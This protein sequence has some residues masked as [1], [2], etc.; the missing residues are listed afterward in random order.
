MPWRH[1]GRGMLDDT[2][3]GRS[4]AEEGGSWHA[5]GR[6]SSQLP[7]PPVDGLSAAAMPLQVDHTIAGSVP[8]PF[9]AGDA[10]PCPWPCPCDA[11]APN[12]A[13]GCRTGVKKEDDDNDAPWL[14]PLK[15][16]LPLLLVL[17]FTGVDNDSPSPLAA[18]DSEEANDGVPAPARPP[19]TTRDLLA[20]VSVLLCRCATRSK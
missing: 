4:L 5:G 2:R 20:A 3:A 6:C 8:L 15:P 14:T 10:K 11:P 9:D 18:D 7:H 13:C 19:P 17:A 12:D 16:A 1:D